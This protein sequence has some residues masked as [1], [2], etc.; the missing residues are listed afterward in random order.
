MEQ[1]RSWLRDRGSSPCSI[2]GS[3]VPDPGGGRQ[4]PRSRRK[5]CAKEVLR[6]CPQSILGK[7]GF[8]FIS[9]QYPVT[10]V[11]R[12]DS[13]VVPAHRKPQVAAAVLYSPPPSAT[14][15]SEQDRSQ[16][17]PWSSRPSGLLFSGQGEGNRSMRT[18]TSYRPRILKTLH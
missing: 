7:W 8:V 10:T 3:H 16:P 11:V 9:G 14:A 15:R 12:R 5:A 1:G 13:W 6:H 2:S 17:F 18:L 4:E